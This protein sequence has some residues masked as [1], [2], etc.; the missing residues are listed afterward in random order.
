MSADVVIKDL[1]PQWIVSVREVIPNY[2]AIGELYPKIYNQIG[3]MSPELGMPLAIWHDAE[4]K[5]H[6]VDG[7]A[8]FFLKQPLTSHGSAKMYQLSE[9]RVASYMHHGPFSG[10]NEAYAKLLRWVQENQYQVAGP[11]RELYHQ[12]SQPV[13]QDDE[14]DVTEIQ[15]PVTRAEPLPVKG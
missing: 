8:A 9:M 10:L 14:S 15:V 7:E 3:D 6:D 12:M 13:R 1:P 5:M 11:M 4:Y 2:P